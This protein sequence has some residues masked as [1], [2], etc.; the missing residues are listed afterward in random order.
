MT[1]KLQHQKPFKRSEL[2]PV[3]LTDWRDYLLTSEPVFDNTD[4]GKQD[5]P[6]FEPDD[7]QELT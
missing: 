1:Q 2:N 3:S 7:T 4:A 6:A 5:K